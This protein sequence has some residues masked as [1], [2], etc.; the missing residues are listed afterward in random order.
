MSRVLPIGFKLYPFSPIE[1]IYDFD[2]KLLSYTLLFTRPDYPYQIYVKLGPDLQTV[3]EFYPWKLNGLSDKECVKLVTDP[4]KKSGRRW[5]L[6]NL[7]KTAYFSVDSTSGKITDF[8]VEDDFLKK[9]DYVT[10]TQKDVY[11]EMVGW[12]DGNEEKRKERLEKASKKCGIPESVVNWLEDESKPNYVYFYLD[13]ATYT[14]KK[15]KLLI[16]YS[17]DPWKKDPRWA[18]LMEQ[19][20]VPGISHLQM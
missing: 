12:G 10:M 14:A 17:P 13:P 6:D 16:G 19:T 2:A 4:P 15:G 1:M 11:I 5:N 9:F 20:I 18:T 7:Q 3:E 8:Y